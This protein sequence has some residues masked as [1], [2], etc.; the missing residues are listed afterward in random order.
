[1]NVS[2]CEESFEKLKQI[3]TEALILTLLASENFFFVYSDAFLSGLGYVLMQN[4]K[5]IAYASHQLKVDECNY[6]THDLELVAVLSLRQRHWIE[7]LKDFDCV[8]DYHPG[9]AILVA[10]ALSRKV[11][12]ELQAMFAQLSISDDGSLLA[13]WRIKPM[14]FDRIK[15]ALLEDDKLVKK[16]EMVQNG[17]LENFSIDDYDC[18]RFRNRIYVLDVSKLKELILH[19]A[20]DCPFSL[21]PGGTKMYRD[22]Q[23]SY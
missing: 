14:M 17:M 5:V 7:L 16:R 10:D 22:L 12:I 8:I 3:L 23:E 6:P 13:E 2:E 18:L 20:H 21:Y 4:E 9:K 11:A 15:S 1:M 19:K